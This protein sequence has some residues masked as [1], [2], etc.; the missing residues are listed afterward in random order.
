[1]GPGPIGLKTVLLTSILA[2]TMPLTALHAQA[3]TAKHKRPASHVSATHHVYVHG[4]ASH[5]EYV[6]HALIHRPYVLVHPE[7]GRHSIGHRIARSEAARLES[8]DDMTHH[9]VFRH[10]IGHRV[11]WGGISCVPF[12]RYDSGINLVGDAWQWWGLAA[13]VYARGRV[14]EMGS[15]LAFKSNPHMRLGHVAVVSRVINRR[16]I[17]IDQ[18]NWWSDGLRGSVSRDVPVVDVSEAN[19]WT[20][21][22][23]GLGYSSKFGAVYPTHGFIYD[24]PDTG[25][26]TADVTAPAPQPVLNPAPRDLR[27]EVERPWKTYEEVAEAP[28]TPRGQR[29][30]MRAV[31]LRSMVSESAP[32]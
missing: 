30:V 32:K 2:V 23:V 13:G 19:D 6:H 9:V 15:V 11:A 4:A 31:N 22:R 18:A 12:A 25:V 24:R 28:E 27:P 8:R 5:H 1:M 21:V 16:E 3:S 10:Y 17:E 20:A 7:Y 26:I 14:P 29:P